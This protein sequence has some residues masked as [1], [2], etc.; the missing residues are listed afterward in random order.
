[1]CLAIIE[2]YRVVDEERSRVVRHK[3]STKKIKYQK[4]LCKNHRYLPIFWFIST[5]HNDLASTDKK[6]TC[7]QAH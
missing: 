1:M 5:I 2:N 7:A 4:L 6:H 3:I